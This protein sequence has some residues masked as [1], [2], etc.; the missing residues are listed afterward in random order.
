MAGTGTAM[1][2]EPA[3]V[4]ALWYLARGTG[5]VCLALLT[6]VVVLG[7]GSR[8][9]RPVFGL[10]RFAVST[11]H[12]NASVMALVL[13]VVHMT[14]LYF[15]PYAQLRL[16]DLM[17]PFGAAY[18]PLWLGLGTVAAD[19]LFVLMATSLLR[20]YLGARTWRAVHWIAYALWPAALLHALG[21]GTDAGQLWL[22]VV[23]GVCVAAVLAAVGWRCTPRFAEMSRPTGRPVF[24]RVDRPQ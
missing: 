20:R 16:F 14:S 22:R 18:R 7:V 10:P 24:A 6:V 4:D 19:L 2:D 13:V 5:V 15:D 12:R 17:V 21:T 11:V 8:S 3:Y 1:T 23:A 9:G